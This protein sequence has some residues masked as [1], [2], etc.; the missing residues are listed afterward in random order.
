MKKAIYVTARELVRHSFREQLKASAPQ[1]VIL[2]SEEG[3]ATGFA[4]FCREMMRDE[5]RAVLAELRTMGIATASGGHVASAL[6][7][8][9]LFDV[10][11]YWFRMDEQGVRVTD[12]NFCASSREAMAYISWRAGQLL[13]QLPSVGHRYYFLPDEPRDAVCH[14]PAC[15]HLSAAQQRMIYAEAVLEGLRAKDQA[16]EVAYPVYE[17]DECLPRDWRA[18]IFL[19]GTDSALRRHGARLLSVHPAEHM[20]ATDSVM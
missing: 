3:G 20:T 15:R 4:Q 5:H 7:P 13:A 16:A 19:I 14:C 6:L 10:Y 9:G 8:R 11:P 18:G 17:E 12:A 1:E 2:W